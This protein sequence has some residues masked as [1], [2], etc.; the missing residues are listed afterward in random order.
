MSGEKIVKSQEGLTVPNNPII[1][2]II[3]DGI[4]PDIWNAASRVIDAAVEEAY[5][6][7]KK[8]EWKEV[9]AGQ[10]AYDETGEWLPK[11]TLDTINEYLIAIKGPLTTPI[12]GGIRSLNVA[13]RQEL[14]LFT[15]LR[16]VRWFQGVPSPVKRPED[17]D[18]VI[19]RENTE[20]I[21]A[22]IEFQEGTP[23]VKKLIEF[24]QNEMGAK[25]IRF[26][27]TSGI[28]VKPVSKE[29]TERL[30]RASIQYAL[31]NNRKSLTL[32]HKGN[33]MK[34]TEG[35][36]K[37]WG[38]DL[39]HNEFGDKVFTWQ[40]YDEIVE[41]EGKDKANEAQEKA[42]KE[43]KIIVKDSIADIFLQQILTRPSDHDVVATMNLNGDYVSDALAAQVGG[44]GIAPGANINYETGHAIFE[45]THGTAPKYAGLNK[46]NPSSEILSAT[47]ML[48]HLGW[49]EAADKITESIEKTIAS[50][51]VTYDFARLMDGAKEVSTS[52]FAD[53]LIKNIK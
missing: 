23:E 11:E 37:Q 3:G 50:K 25:N 29:G 38:Y 48:E 24:L 42:E 13:L 17:T 8:I 41:K 5:N 44:I 32:V 31:E 39:A 45:A 51:V 33:I 20:D 10:K 27:E 43:G 47:L 30:V 14:D 19:F 4:G 46:V 15:C 26:P 22:G 40:Q 52:E 18:M 6:G 2:F 28:G 12:G 49:Q 35:A 9:L 7:E 1:P 21:Y 53:E 36:F 16:P 34:F